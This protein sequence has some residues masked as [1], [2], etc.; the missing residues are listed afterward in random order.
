MV[1]LFVGMAFVIAYGWWVW[2]SDPH[3]LPRGQTLL[4][5]RQ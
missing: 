2:R 5:R 1:G 4:S 3:R